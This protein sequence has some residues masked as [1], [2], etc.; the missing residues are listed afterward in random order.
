MKVCNKYT[1]LCK[2]SARDM[3]IKIKQPSSVALTSTIFARR[4]E[5]DIC[6]LNVLDVTASAP[7]MTSGRGHWNGISS[8]YTSLDHLQIRHVKR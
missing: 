6:R 2:H 7:V 1:H 5:V 8:K 3:N 4:Y